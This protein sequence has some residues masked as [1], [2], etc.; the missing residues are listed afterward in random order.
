MVSSLLFWTALRRSLV[1][2]IN[3]KTALDDQ[4]MT[5][6]GIYLLMYI[7]IKLTCDITSLS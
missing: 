6:L 4:R 2:H 3:K 5:K 1:L 7:L